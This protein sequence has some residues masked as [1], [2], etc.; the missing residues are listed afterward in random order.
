MPTPPR[1]AIPQP[2]STDSEYNERSWPQYAEAIKR[3]GG[4][5]V[6]IPLA[7]SQDVLA[8]L[9]STCSAVLLP[10]S[11]ADVDPEKYGAER[12]AE[13]G[14]KDPAR[15]A[16]DELLLQDAF[17]LKKPILGICYGLQSLN[18]WKS[19]KLIQDLDR[20]FEKNPTKL[21]RKVD[22][23]PGRTVQHAHTIAVEPDSQLASIL[24][25]AGDAEKQANLWRVSVN[26]SHHQAIAEPGDRMRVVARSTD[27]RVI[28]ALEDPHAPQFLLGVQWH[29]E[30]TYELSEASRAIFQ[31]FVEAAAAWKPTPIATSLADFAAG[32]AQRA[33]NARNPGT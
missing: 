18:V 21:S 27:D 2:T 29:P 7:E 32:E 26:S 10:G 24:K 23:K 31:A 3:A 30:R 25:D 11:G 28:E 33:D 19:G 17:N 8:R 4:S 1:I 12:I 20:F 13:C 22:H 15:E 16:A 5:A 14:A 6:E 9:I